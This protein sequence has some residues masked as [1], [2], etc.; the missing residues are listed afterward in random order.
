VIWDWILVNPNKQGDGKFL[1]DSD[2]F[3]MAFQFWFGCDQSTSFGVITVWSGW[4][5]FKLWIPLLV[6][7]FAVL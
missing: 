7:G 6:L 2:G 5:W 1:K 4:I 3:W